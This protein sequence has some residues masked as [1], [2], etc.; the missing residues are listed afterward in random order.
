MPVDEIILTGNMAKDS[1]KITE[2]LNKIVEERCKNINLEEK[3]KNKIAK[4]KCKIKKEVNNG[5]KL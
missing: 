4:E 2:Y 3:D 1:V 5:I